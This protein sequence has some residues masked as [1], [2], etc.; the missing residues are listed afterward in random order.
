ME[1]KFVWAKQTSFIAED[2]VECRRF[3]IL[4]D[5]AARQTD[6][7]VQLA[8][9]CNDMHLKQIDFNLLQIVMGIKFA[10]VRLG[11]FIV[12]NSTEQIFLVQM[13]IVVRQTDLSVKLAGNCNN[14]YHL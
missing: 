10:Q 1:L 13:D 8:G 11:G 6:L 14:M 2:I 7:S 4:T 12:E 5:I 3:Q 9:T